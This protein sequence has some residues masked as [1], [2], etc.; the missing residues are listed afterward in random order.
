M[1]GR[2]EETQGP[3][4][5]KKNPIQAAGCSKIERD[6]S[7]TLAQL[8]A[9]YILPVKT[10]LQAAETERGAF[11]KHVRVYLLLTLLTYC[12]DREGNV[13]DTPAS[14]FSSNIVVNS[15]TVENKVTLR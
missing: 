10:P 4:F 11:V 13:C 8:L 15:I 14:V 3:C 9:S 12:V 7:P 5:S 1:E 2:E 6:M